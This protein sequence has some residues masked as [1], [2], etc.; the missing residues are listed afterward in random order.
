MYRVYIN[1]CVRTFTAIY[2][3]GTYISHT[4]YFLL[5]FTLSFQVATYIFDTTVV[6][7]SI[8]TDYI[9]SRRGTSVSPVEPFA[10]IYGMIDISLQALQRENI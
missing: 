1:V 9:I 8:D 6:N 4:I 5:I 10:F 3:S 7:V 2:I